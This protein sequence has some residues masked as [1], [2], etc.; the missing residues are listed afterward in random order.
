MLTLGLVIYRSWQWKQYSLDATWHERG[1]NGIVVDTKKI[2]TGMGRKDGGL[3][4]YLFPFQSTSY[5]DPSLN[6]GRC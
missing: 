2:E 5:L 1:V 4:L 3:R 6:D